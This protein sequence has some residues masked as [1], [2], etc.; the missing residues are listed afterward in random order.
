MKPSKH[1]MLQFPG[2]SIRGATPAR[3]S[4]EE[5][6]FS[7]RGGKRF[8]ACNTVTFPT[9]WIIIP[10]PDGETGGESTHGNHNGVGSGGNNNE[11][12]GNND[13]D[14]NDWNVVVGRTTEFLR[15]K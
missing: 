12:N 1:R 6:Y 10:D 11:N 15:L 8:S 7:V 13:D 2:H 4:A 3:H 14:Q 5:W 9:E